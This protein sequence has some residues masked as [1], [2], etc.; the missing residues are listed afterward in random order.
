MVSNQLTE[1]MQHYTVGVDGNF[2]P[3][4]LKTDWIQSTVSHIFFYT[5]HLNKLNQSLN[6]VA[7]MDRVIGKIFMHQYGY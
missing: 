1:M 5:N 6:A 2:G 4:G 3:Y 7:T